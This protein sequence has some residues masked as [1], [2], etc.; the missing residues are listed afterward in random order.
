VKYFANNEIGESVGRKYFWR[1]AN[2]DDTPYFE[3]NTSLSTLIAQD[4]M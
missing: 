1:V 2:G 4:I 3:G